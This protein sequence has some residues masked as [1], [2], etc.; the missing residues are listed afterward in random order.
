VGHVAGAPVI[1][2]PSWLVAVVVLTVVSVPGAG[3]VTQLDGAAVWVAALAFVVLLFVSVFL[4][5][6]AH[7][8]VARARGQQPQEFVLTL[9]GGHTS[10]GGA[11]PIPATN[12]LVA[13]VGPVVNLALAALFWAGLVLEVAPQR[14]VLWALLGSGAITN[15]FVGVF[16]LLPGLPLDG[17]RVLESVVWSLT[18][19]RY[20]GTV[21]AAWVGRVVA[22]GVVVW[23]LV[24]LLP[25]DGSGSPFELVWAV[26]IGAFLWSGASAAI[27][28]ARVQR[29]VE[30]MT[31]ATVGRPAVAVGHGDSL[32]HASSVASAAGVQDVV[33]LSPDGRAAA[34]VDRAAAASV[35]AQ[36]AGSTPVTAVSIPLPVGATVDGALV[37]AP[38][39]NELA[40]TARVSPVVVALV[41]GKVVG[42]VHA[43]DVV[44]AIRA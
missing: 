32:A 8:L 30:V 15:G 26:L 11:A 27:R 13:I 44:A 2:A 16:N 33:V 24:W 10:F 22:V 6:L 23:A 25:A 12:A 34:Y 35:P 1:L 20:T 29:K 21:A 3:N 14:S 4:H 40:R 5:E 17:G 28:A 43:P 38:L 36:A 18:K 37:G 7:G 39:L 31:F 41:D 9:W 19:D 42:L